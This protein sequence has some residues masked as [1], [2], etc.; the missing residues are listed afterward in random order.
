[1]NL[2]KNDISREIRLEFIIKIRKNLAD[3]FNQDAWISSFEKYNES[4]NNYD[5]LRLVLNNCFKSEFKK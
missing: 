5:N 1:M 2:V 3:K 4:R